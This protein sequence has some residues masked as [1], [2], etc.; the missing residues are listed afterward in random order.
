MEIEQKTKYPLEDLM[1]YLEG[2]I[3]KIEI[4]STLGRQYIYFPEHPIL[5]KLSHP[6]RN[7]IML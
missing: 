2:K 6:T 1:K 4:V 7:R 3:L 5:T